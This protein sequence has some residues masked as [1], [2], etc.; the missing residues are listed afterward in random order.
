MRATSSSTDSIDVNWQA[1]RDDSVTGYRVDV[2]IPSDPQ[3]SFSQRYPA[4]TNRAT[5]PGLNE[6]SEYQVSVV[7]T[8]ESGES[9]PVRK[10]VK[11]RKSSTSI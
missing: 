7:S 4:R 8:S 11:T 1:P 10:S 9:E 2:G 6:N 5:I 3:R